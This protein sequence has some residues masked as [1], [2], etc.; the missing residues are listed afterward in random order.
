MKQD[1]IKQNA[2]AHIQKKLGYSFRN[3]ELLV[4]ALTHRSYSAKNNE[5][6]E[7]IGDA[8]LDYTVAKML[9]DAFPKLSEGE[10]SRLR[11]NLVNEAVLAD[12]AIEMNIGEAL[13]LGTG[14][15]KSGGFRRPSIL[16]DAVEALFA[17]VSL[18][19]DFSEAESVVRR[20]FSGRVKTVDFKNQGKD[21]K[22]LLQEALQARRFD[23]PKYRIEEQTTDAQDVKFT[24]SCDLGELG[25]I[26]R[27]TGGSRKSA[28]QE[29]AKEAIV[30]VEKHYPQRKAKR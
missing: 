8:V 19:A 24:V 12:I 15:L 20:L 27:A 7:F 23:L 4:Q 29:A 3:T 30:W 25:F 6:L 13:F 2:L 28:E 9:F 22:T 11:S 26:C 14:E 18:D 5:R 10:L 1:L 17:A 16:A 21:S